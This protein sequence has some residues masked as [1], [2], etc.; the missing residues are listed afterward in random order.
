MLNQ[1]MAPGSFL[2]ALRRHLRAALTPAIG[3]GWVDLDAG[4]FYRKALGD[5][6]TKKRQPTIR[7]PDRSLA[8]TRRWRAKG[9]SARP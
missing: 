2:D 4:L 8:R 5:K 7:I 3:R 9:I 6:K 1:N